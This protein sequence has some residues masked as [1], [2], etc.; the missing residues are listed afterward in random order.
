MM[1]GAYLIPVLVHSPVRSSQ[2]WLCIAA[3]ASSQSPPGDAGGLLL[4]SFLPLPD[5]LHESPYMLW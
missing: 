4:A 2:P 3:A 5:S 1:P